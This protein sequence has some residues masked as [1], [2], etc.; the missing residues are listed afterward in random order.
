MNV[1]LSSL[2]HYQ[3][4]SSIREYFKGCDVSATFAG[5][6]NKRRFITVKWQA[7]DDENLLRASVFAEGTETVIDG[8][9]IITSTSNCSIEELHFFHAARFAF[10][11]LEIRILACPVYFFPFVSDGSFRT[12]RFRR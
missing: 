6:N 7:A 2:L 3:F 10:S 8:H 9:L 5:E 11:G 12:V 1:S 4:S